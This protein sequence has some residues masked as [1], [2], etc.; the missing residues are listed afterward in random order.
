MAFEM[1]LGRSFL[2][3]KNDE[4]SENESLTATK[5]LHCQQ[6]PS[7]VSSILDLDLSW[8]IVGFVKSTEH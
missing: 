7:L 6:F 8:F 4:K 1:Q 3:E 2:K 5:A